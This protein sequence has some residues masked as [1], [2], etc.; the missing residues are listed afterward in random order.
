M[1]VLTIGLISLAE[2]LAVTLRLQ[3]L[4]RNEMHA[5]R[6]AQDKLDQLMSLDWTDPKIAVSGG[7]LTS[8]GANHFDTQAGPDGTLGNADDIAEMAGYTRRWVLSTHPD[9]A[10]LRN[11]TIRVIPEVRD[12]RT[13]STYDL[14]SIIRDW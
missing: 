12:N 13:A 5:V 1:V 9:G 4:G 6:L 7:S 10:N 8:N 2:M 11:I 14:V 3:Q